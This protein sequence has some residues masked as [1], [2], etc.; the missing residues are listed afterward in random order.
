MSPIIINSTFP[1]PILADFHTYINYCEAHRLVVTKKNEVIN[2]KDVFALNEQMQEK[3]LEATIRMNQSS[4]MQLHLFQHLCLEGRLFG[5][6][7]EKATTFYFE[8]QPEKLSY[9]RQLNQTEQY[10]YLFKTLW[11]YSNWGNLQIKPRSRYKP[12]LLHALFVWIAKNTST[13]VYLNKDDKLG[14]IGEELGT[15]LFHLE[16]FGFWKVEWKKGEYY[17]EKTRPQVEALTVSNFGKQMAEIL[18]VHGKIGRWNKY[19]QGYLDLVEY[20]EANSKVE[21]L[22]KAGKSEKEAVKIVE[23][24]LTATKQA[25]KD[26]LFETPF[27]SLFPEGDLG[28]L[29]IRPPARFSSGTYTFKVNLT[30]QKKIWRR[31]QLDAKATLED[32]HNMIQRAFDF[33][34][35]HLYAFYMDGKRFSDLSYNDPRG[36]DGPFADEI[37]LGACELLEINR[38]IFYLF[39]FGTEWHF[40]V[41]LESIDENATPLKKGKVIESKGESPEQYGGW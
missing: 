34:D 15:S 7:R 41:V 22:V 3:N 28:I 21:Q 33:G 31:I 27:Q 11:V 37:E 32:L 24:E 36:G 16:L 40:D 29:A 12:N 19:Y 13:K 14:R 5:I 39:D 18:A 17:E 26:I 2:R 8:P 4:Y 30:H 20:F 23:Q 38:K 10:F 1:S 9:F 35:D 6:N 25:Q